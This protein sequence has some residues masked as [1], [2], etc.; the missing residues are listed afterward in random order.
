MSKITFLFGAGASAQK[1]PVVS[2]MPTTLEKTIKLIQGKEYQL[3]NEK[4]KNTRITGTETKSF[5]QKFL[6]N[7]LKWLKE[8]SENHASIDTFAKKL[9]ITGKIKDLRRLKLST[10]AFFAI[11]QTQLEWSNNK[12]DNR[13]DTFFASIMDTSV[14]LPENIKVLSWNYD[15]QFEMAYVDYSTQHKD[16]QS[17]SLALNI[18]SK[19]LGKRRTNG[20]A[21][22][23]LNGSASFHT[24]DGYFSHNYSDT[25]NHRF[26][27]DFF[28]EVLENYTISNLNTNIIPSLSFAWESDT[29]RSQSISSYAANEIRNTEILVIIGYSFPFFNREIDKL[30]FNRMTGLKKIYYQDINA[31]N[32]VTRL[33]SVVHDNGII[34][35]TKVIK[36]VDQFFL[37]YEF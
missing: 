21:I 1:L 28:Q 17:S 25:Y 27:I 5:Y 23:K 31:A 18:M 24:A 10:S 11:N 9:S 4:F 26:N 22:M 8:M 29:Y 33:S 15:S 13:Y 35:N 7:E 2:Q 37:P 32:L 20:F 19:H 30:L 16:I 14:G 12:I 3:P 6:I 36:D 34:E